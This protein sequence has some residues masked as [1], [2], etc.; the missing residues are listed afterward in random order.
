MKIMLLA[1]ATEG[2]ELIATFEAIAELQQTRRDDWYFAGNGNWKP[3]AVQRL[4][5][6]RHIFRDPT[7][8]ARIF[9]G[10]RR[11]FHS[12]I[13]SF[14]ALR[15]IRRK[16][17]MFDAIFLTDYRFF[18]ASAVLYPRVRKIFL[19]HNFRSLFPL[20]RMFTNPYALISGLHE[21]FAWMLSSRVLTPSEYAREQ[22]LRHIPS[23]YR[24]HHVFVA[25]NILRPPFL[26]QHPADELR[27]FRESKDIPGRAPLI[28]YS[29]RMVPEKGLG[30]LAEAFPRISAACPEAVIVLAYI[31]QNTDK[32]T[33]SRWTALKEKRPDNVRLLADLPVEELPL[34]MQT[35]T[36]GILPSYIEMSSLFLLESLASGLPLF[37]VDAGTTRELFGSISGAFVLRSNDPRDI[38]ASLI[39]YLRKPVP[40]RNRMRSRIRK[41]WTVYMRDRKGRTILSESGML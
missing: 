31:S 4:F 14:L 19:F 17:G 21:R 28:V 9:P 27:A 34:L 24:R 10:Y 40:Y 35:A 12:Y 13:H 39:R 15:Q 37:G 36:C 29:G 26:R 41:R 30:Q 32:K 11:L 20:S 3:G 25:P 38:A 8:R 1:D 33:M 22:V 7:V 5:K 6:K 23:R 16:W 2:G 18:L